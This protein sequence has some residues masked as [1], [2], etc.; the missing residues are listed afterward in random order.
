MQNFI[1]S[2]NAKAVATVVTDL[3]TIK[4]LIL[5][6]G[7]NLR[8]HMTDVQKSIEAQRLAEEKRK[9][10]LQS[11]WFDAM[12]DR[13]S[14][15]EESYPETFQWVFTA[16]EGDQRAAFKTWLSSQDDRTF[17]I[18]GKP[19]SGKSTLM[20]FLQSEERTLQYLEEWLPGCVIYRY[21]IWN[22]GERLQKN[23]KGMF[24]SLIHQILESKD[25]EYLL[26]KVLEEYP[27]FSR[28]K[29]HYDWELKE[30]EKLLP[31]L[32]IW[33][34]APVCLFIDGLDEIDQGENRFGLKRM[35]EDSVAQISHLKICVSS[36]PEPF[37]VRMLH[38]CSSIKIQDFTEA[39]LRKIA[40][41]LLKKSFEAFFS[42]KPKSDLEKLIKLTVQ[43]SEGVF[44]WVALAIKSLE[45][46][47]SGNDD[48]EEL[49]HRIDALPPELN[50]LYHNMWA[51]LGADQAMYQEKAAFYLNFLIIW[52]KVSM[53]EDSPLSYQVALALDDA[54]WEKTM[55][56]G[57]EVFQTQEFLDVCKNIQH[58][59]ETRCA[60]LL[61]FVVHANTTFVGRS[62]D[63][64]D[65]RILAVNFVHRTARDFLLT[66]QEGKNVLKH[67]DLETVYRAVMHSLLVDVQL[68]ENVGLEF[69]VQYTGYNDRRV[70]TFKSCW[71]PV[72]NGIDRRIVAAMNCCRD[73]EKHVQGVSATTGTL[74]DRQSAKIYELLEKAGERLQLVDFLEALIEIHGFAQ[75]VVK[76]T[77]LS[78]KDSTSLAVYLFWQTIPVGF[79]DTWF[80]VLSTGTPDFDWEYLHTTELSFQSIPKLC[81]I[82]ESLG[83]GAIFPTD[84]LL[85]SGK[86][87]WSIHEL[88]SLFDS[89][90]SRAKN[91]NTF[92][93]LT[94]FGDRGMTDCIAKGITLSYV[95]RASE[96]SD[97]KEFP[98][99]FDIVSDLIIEINTA[100]IVNNLILHECAR[101]D[102][103]TTA[104]LKSARLRKFLYPVEECH[105]R[106]LLVGNFRKRVEVDTNDRLE[107]FDSQQ[108]LLSL[109]ESC[110]SGG[111][112]FDELWDALSAKFS[113][114]SEEISNAIIS[115]LE[116]MDI[117]API[118][119]PCEDENASFIHTPE[120]E[121]SL[122]ER[123]ETPSTGVE[124]IHSLINKVVSG[125]NERVLNV[126]E[127]LRGRGHFVPTED[128][129]KEF[130]SAK[131]AYARVTVLDRL[132]RE[133]R[134][135]EER[136][137]L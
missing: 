16:K 126:P 105:L 119:V 38:N 95:P 96:N 24:C 6:E 19:G 64:T 130:M 76:A 80:Q 81:T 84:P 32:L 83:F 89:T 110:P 54:L 55:T 85:G 118:L 42:G 30:L 74:W 26:L 129:L 90:G 82:T 50:D 52:K 21:F 65:P 1:Q 9:L 127:F 123:L 8:Q 101:L 34:K 18:K 134:E 91:R 43:K 13:Q 22:S 46:G 69:S 36:R 133:K 47:F 3:S 106:V 2:D 99:S 116:K 124:R 131:D 121:R 59:V 103:Q 70:D 136:F 122:T 10:I 112:H 61:E 120:T 31:K 41:D 48:L 63:L 25:N 45:R 75:P 109:S 125:S 56:G 114:P 58:Y 132:N 113:S 66:T 68:G 49:E 107:V 27:Q 92:A 33:H 104:E 71:T 102:K 4:Q 87:K 128:D 17:W 57:N 111:V 135:M 23:L 11:L 44:L 53:G 117:P 60:G 67:C 115:E 98:K 5:S 20:K 73:W 100:Q 7:Q 93:G 14:N 97:L 86:A 51:R 137:A 12:N 62:L 35:V 94:L 77:S 108:K 88:V 29:S 39:D 15:I 72:D 78:L 37:W 40:E 79:D 28:K